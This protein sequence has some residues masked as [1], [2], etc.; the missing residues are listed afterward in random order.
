M[1]A[2]YCCTRAPLVCSCH[3]TTLMGIWSLIRATQCGRQQ[4]TCLSFRLLGSHSDAQKGRGWQGIVTLLGLN[5][6][7]A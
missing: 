3:Q 4:C 5:L 1:P 6:R 2:L 7:V